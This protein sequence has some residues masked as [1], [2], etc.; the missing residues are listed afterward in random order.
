MGRGG[1]GGV[2]GRPLQPTDYII[3]VKTVVIRHFVKTENS[4]A[5]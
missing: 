3:T 1:G 5:K 4:L 2:H